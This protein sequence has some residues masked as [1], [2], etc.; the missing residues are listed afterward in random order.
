MMGHR[1][2]PHLLAVRWNVAAY[3]W[4][5]NRIKS[6]DLPAALDDTGELAK[7]RSLPLFDS[8]ES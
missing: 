4:T 5:L 1:D 7:E 3:L 2:E 6:G 8:P